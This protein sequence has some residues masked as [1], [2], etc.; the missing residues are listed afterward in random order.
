MLTNSFFRKA[1]ALL[2][3]AVFLISC[4]TEFTT[5]GTDIV[6]DDHFG[7]EADNYDVNSMSQ[8]TGAVQS[9]NLPVN[10][11]GVFNNGAFGKTTANF[12]T[13]V[14]LKVAAPKFNNVTLARIE[15][16]VL[17][18][19]YY[20]TFVETKQNTDGDAENIYELDSVYGNLEN[21]INLKIYENGY[22]LRDLDPSGDFQTAQKFY[23]DQ[24]PMFESAKGPWLNDATAPSQNTG[25]AFSPAELVDEGD[26][27][28]DTDDVRSAPGMKLDLNKAFFYNKIFTTDAS[29]LANSNAFK[30]YFRGLY[31]NVEEVGGNGSMAMLNFAQ[32]TITIKYK[33]TPGTDS[34]VDPV[35]KSLV[36]GLTG[37]T[38][39]LLEH[40]S[41]TASA[42][43]ENFTDP[44]NIYLKGGNG[45]IAYID[46]FGGENSLLLDEIRNNVISKNWLVNE[47][48]LV[49]SVDQTDMAQ[50]IDP[51]R[52]YLYDAK[53]NS[54]VV[55]YYFDSSTNGAKP[56]YG[57]V[58][59]GGIAKLSG[60]SGD[61]SRKATEYKIRITEHI[62]NV[63]FKDSTNVRLGLAVTENIG[64][65]TY[66]NL[67]T[68]SAQFSRVPVSSVLSPLGTILYGSNPSV[69]VEKRLKLQ[70]YYTKPN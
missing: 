69:P 1:S 11:L 38:V 44:Q 23:S 5:I 24:N 62:K 35:D 61:A 59:Y 16:V 51:N 45:S 12:V 29:N 37:N 36:L 56:K 50:T 31:F 41:T 48:N 13:Q 7:L 27:D 40:T 54:P 52:I 68:P 39:S 9:N 25:F 33:D 42:A 4:D 14:D 20:S 60:S 64:L 19:P 70:I 3:G 57:K 47:A 46:L 49:F 67:K 55:D 10:P 15:S 53:N 43:Y 18:I 26:P 2:F 22:Y 6:G 32:G 66:A 17:N 58:L 63:L 34:A 65:I 28:D 21:K 30:N 8:K